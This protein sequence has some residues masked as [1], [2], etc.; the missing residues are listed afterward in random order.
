[1]SRHG[2]DVWATV[3]HD[4][5]T[6]VKRIGRR[7]T[8]LRASSRR[9]TAASSSAQSRGASAV[10]SGAAETR[11]E[12]V[13]CHTA[14]CATDP[15]ATGRASTTRAWALDARRRAADGRVGRQWARG[16]GRKRGGGV[17]WQKASESNRKGQR[18][19]S[20][21][22]RMRRGGS[23][24]RGGRWVA[25]CHGV[26][27][28]A[29]QRARVAAARRGC[30]EQPVSDPPRREPRAASRIARASV[31]LASFSLA[32]SHVPIARCMSNLSLDRYQIG[33]KGW[34]F[35]VIIINMY[36][37][38]DRA[39]RA[40][41]ISTRGSVRRRAGLAASGSAVMYCCDK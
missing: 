31:T 21:D 15:P 26:R 37:E 12:L 39:A 40:T 22:G 2:G 32:T 29:A 35:R 20:G 18:T 5:V 10:A 4:D 23:V 19:E 27:L 36:C 24:G 34:P 1:M 38:R 25:T 30:G 11:S 7:S 6:N 14:V 28:A 41:S 17:G 16:R 9:A 13:S 8:Y 3:A 33:R